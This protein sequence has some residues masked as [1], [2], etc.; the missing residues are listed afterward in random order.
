[1][2]SSFLEAFENWGFGTSSLLALERAESVDN[3]LP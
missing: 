1:M 2:Y 3:L